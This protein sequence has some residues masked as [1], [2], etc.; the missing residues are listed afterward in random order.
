MVTVGTTSS[1]HLLIKP[2][3]DVVYSSMPSAESWNMFQSVIAK[4]S[5]L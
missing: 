1:I 3:T 4:Q 2:K 5:V